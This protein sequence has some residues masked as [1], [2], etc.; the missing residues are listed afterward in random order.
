MEGMSGFSHL[1]LGLQGVT[2][3]AGKAAGKACLEL[4]GLIRATAAKW[5]IPMTFSSAQLF[6][7][8]GYQEISVM[9]RWKIRRLMV[10]LYCGATNPQLRRRN[11]FANR[12]AASGDERM[13][14]ARPWAVD[15]PRAPVRLILTSFAAGVA[16]M[17]LLGLIAPTIAMGG[18]AM[19][20]ASAST[21]DHQAPLIQPLDV[22]A[23]KARLASAQAQLDAERR[24]T[25]PV[26]QRLSRIAHD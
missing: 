4:N 25:D 19:R 21:F 9:L 1:L 12:R 26:V 5:P 24:N 22:P 10:K 14:P 17:V 20:T 23:I 11:G 2:A 3:R 15:K 7:Q 8:T 13:S 6:F 18:L 16:A